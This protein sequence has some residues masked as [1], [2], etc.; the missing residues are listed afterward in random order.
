MAIHFYQG[1][2]DG[3]PFGVVLFVCIFDWHVRED[4]RVFSQ[5]FTVLN[6]GIIAGVVRGVEECHSNKG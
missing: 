6:V 2:G 4:R 1:D 5:Q 3:D